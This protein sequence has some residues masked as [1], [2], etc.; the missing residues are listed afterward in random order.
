MFLELLHL[1]HFGVLYCNIE[2][3]LV[4]VVGCLGMK[5]PSAPA[6]RSINTNHD[7]LASKSHKQSFE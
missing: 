6:E 3:H 7:G 2:Q 4:F 1:F 5:T